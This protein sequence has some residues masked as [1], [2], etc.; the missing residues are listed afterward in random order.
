MFH[1]KK[2]SF[3]IAA[4]ILLV[5]TSSF[6]TDKCYC[7]E[8][9]N[10]RYKF[11]RSDIIK[12]RMILNNNTEK[13]GMASSTGERTITDQNITLDY[14]QSIQNTPTN[15]IMKI[16]STI[17]AFDISMKKNEKELPVPGEISKEIAGKKFFFTMKDNGQ[18]LDFYPPQ[19]IYDAPFSID[20]ISAVIEHLYPALPEKEIKIG[21][22][23]L[24]NFEIIAPKPAEGKIFSSFNYT[25]SGIENI[26][27]VPC[28]VI[29]FWGT[30]R[31]YFENKLGT[32]DKEINIIGSSEGK[33]YISKKDGTIVKADEKMTMNIIS[34]IN[35]F[36]EG[37][38]DT[39]H[40]QDT[41]KTDISV[42]L[43]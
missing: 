8:K 23:W 13:R 11:S 25:L 27:D 24:S 28:A 39:K 1:K 43:Q 35:S 34:E 19:D 26:N 6:A 14:S 40:V 15:K 32:K 22:T 10:L 4:L 33:T 30:F 36:S 29:T 2:S 20:I 5:F 41:I 16:V 31:S 18:I 3:C 7:Q 42:E 12:Y 17:S 9:M 38:A 37:K 21:N